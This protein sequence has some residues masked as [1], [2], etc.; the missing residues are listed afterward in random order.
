MKKDAQELET[1]DMGLTRYQLESGVLC[2]LVVA[3]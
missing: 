3:T 1:G 2:F